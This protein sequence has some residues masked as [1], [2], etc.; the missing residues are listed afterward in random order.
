[1]KNAL[2]AV[3]LVGLVSVLDGCGGGSSPFFLATHFSVT[4]STS[5]PASG[6]AFMITVTAVASTGQ[7]ATSYTGTVHFSSSDGQATLPPDTPMTG[8]TGTFSVT[9]NTAGPQTITVSDTGAL[10]GMSSTINVGAGAAAH[11]SV[12][13]ANYIASTGTA[14]S[15]TVTAMDAFGNTA[16]GYSGTV[17]FTSSDAQAVLPP[18]STLTN[19]AGTFSVTLKTS[20]TQTITATDKA[21]SSVNGTSNGITVSGPATHFSVGTLA[22]AKT[23]APINV[24]VTALDASNN[25]STGYT[26]TVH[27]TSVTDVNAILPADQTLQTGSGSFQ[28]T[29]ETAGAE[30]V[31]ATDTA[32][33]SIT[34]TSNS[35]AVTASAPLMITSGSPP[36]GTVG[37]TYGTISTQYL[38]CVSQIFRRICT[39][40]VP[41]TAAC[42]GSYPRCPSPSL[43]GTC[44][45]REDFSGFEL[46]ASGGVPAYNWTGSAL[47]PGLAV[48]TEHGRI[49]ISGTPTPGTAA[50]YNSMVTLNDSGLPPTPMI[51]TYPIVISNPPPP[52]VST[53]PLLPG[54]T[55]NQPFSY[56][57]TA[58]AGLPPYSSWKETGTL[59]AGIAPL[60]SAGVLAGTPTMTGP[61][62]ITVTVDDSLG[63]VSAAQPFNLQVY[64]HGFKAAGAMGAARMN[65]TATLLQDGT[66]LLA[67]GV[68]LAS[69]EIFNASTGVFAATT[70][71]MSV[72]RQQH[73]ATLLSS[74][75]VLI[76]GGSNGSTSLATAE[77]FDPGA[78]KFTPTGNLNVARSGHN[79]TLLT[80]GANGKVL[81][82][83]GGTTTAE[84][85]DPSTG[86]FTATKGA[87]TTA[88]ANETA[89]LLASGKVLITGG[90]GASGE[91]ATA[92]LYDPA[93]DMFT[94]T[95]TMT[96]ARGN[97]SA[98]LLTTGTN[99]GKVL[100][101][102]G[103]NISSAELYDPTAGTFS[104]TG[105][106]ATARAYHAAILLGDG[107]VLMVGGFDANNAILAAVEL[108]DP[109]SG[110]FAGTGGLQTPRAYDA[111]AL[112][113]DGSTV[114]VTGGTAS[115]APL[116]SAEEYQ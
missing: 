103:N 28:V 21:Q 97:Q 79:A 88:R 29:L 70:G 23:R 53:S 49:F 52:V 14:I 58:T 51:A 46:T 33:A 99:S 61:F 7:P 50:T 39:P 26:G 3:T 55:V 31:T 106:M 18:D 41:N 34:G 100:I 73:T 60:T 91:L 11:F 63:Q 27:I 35:I 43:F 94:A 25:T 45:L 20:G 112:L 13:L 2:L 30:T 59:P 38:K 90:F 56:T 76:A 89:T 6:T 109:N 16:T 92:E 83:G 32:T 87:M 8:V 75:K 105:S 110:T 72:A 95:G 4:A 86:M 67:G 17:H 65:H 116:A 66:V 22:T 81:I 78:G 1:M 96:V 44:I 54:A 19:G 102:G 12:A 15:F 64:A 36:N 71:S 85:F 113:K 111:A 101:A 62:P 84:L 93:T 42:G 114:L 74:G 9:L 82:T 57:F 40:C 77:I 47:P 10:A 108:Y 115:G 37:S 80:S 24:V 5:T 104:A 107:T 69:A 68:G 98:T 48:N